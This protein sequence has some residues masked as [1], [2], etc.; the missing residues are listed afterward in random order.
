MIIEGVIFN[1]AGKPLQGASITIAKADGAYTGTGTVTNALG[2]FIIDNANVQ[3]GNILIAS[4]VGFIPFSARLENYNEQVEI[5]LAAD[6]KE[7]PGVTVTAGMDKNSMLWILALVAA[8]KL[9]EGKKTVS[10]VGGEKME[11]VL[12]VGVGVLMLTSFDAIKKIFEN[13]GFWK[14]QNTKDL[15]NEGENPNSFWNP[16]FWKV[17]PAGTLLMTDAGVTQFIKDLKNCFG[18]FSDNEA[19]ALGLFK[20]LKT[21]SQLSYLAEKFQEKEKAELLNWLW[22]DNWPD[23]RLSADELAEINTYMHRLPK[24]RP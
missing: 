2:Y 8:A 5:E 15:E 18:T 16:G 6:V 1:Q 21:Q 19:K 13:F 20:T 24:Y 14:S 12:V 7:L 11:T 10:G 23:D 9:S 4:H 22:K 3:E 17:G